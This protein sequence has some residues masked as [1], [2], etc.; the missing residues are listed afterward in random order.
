VRCRKV[1]IFFQGIKRSEP[2]IHLMQ[3]ELRDRS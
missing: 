1:S 3:F 2:R